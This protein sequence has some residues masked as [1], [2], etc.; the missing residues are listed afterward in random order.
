[1]IVQNQVFVQNQVYSDRGILLND[2]FIAYPDT[3]KLILVLVNY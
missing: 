2:L 1:M 3:H